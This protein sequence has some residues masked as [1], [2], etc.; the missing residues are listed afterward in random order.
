MSPLPCFPQIDVVASTT[1]VSDYLTRKT[2]RSFSLVNHA[3]LHRCRHHLFREIK[4]AVEFTT[5]SH[6]RRISR[7]LP[8]LQHPLSQ[9]A[10][11]VHIVN[12]RDCFWEP[13]LPAILSLLPTIH[14]IHLSTRAGTASWSVF[15]PA[16]KEA[17][18]STLALPA[19]QEVSIKGLVDLPW[20]LLAAPSL[21]RLTLRDSNAEEEVDTEANKST[22][23]PTVLSVHTSFPLLATL[24][25]HQTVCLSRLKDVTLIS[26]TRWDMSRSTDVLRLASAT[27][28][29]I[30][31]TN[32]SGAPN[33]TTSTGDSLAN[34]FSR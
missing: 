3:F 12:M 22:S 24:L 18:L 1:G 6:E 33:P 28:E 20:D 4:L 23:T 25:R 29:R 11:F 14:T 13:E 2:L 30:S 21:A 16:F 19:I 32:V 10:P 26:S 31:F 7:L 15:T 5:P 9:I 8:L 34:L 17:I 27:V